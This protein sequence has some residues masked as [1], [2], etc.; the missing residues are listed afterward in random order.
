MQ[1][2]TVLILSRDPAFSR[3]ITAHWP[4]D[5]A[6]Q[7]DGPEFVV[8]DQAFRGGLESSHYDLAIVDAVLPVK[9]SRKKKDELVAKPAIDNASDAESLSR[10]VKHALVA[11]GKA[12]L[13]I[14]SEPGP[15]FCSV[16]GAVIAVRREAGTWPAMAGLLGSEILRRSQAECHARDAER[17]CHTA[18]AEATL[19][20]YMVEMRT[21]VNNALTTILGN[22]ELLAHEPG[23]PA[24]VQTQADALRNM[25][26]RLHEIFQRFSSIEKELSFAARESRP[27]ATGAAAGVR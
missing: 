10:D 5:P 20:R 25:A 2:S 16:D 22:A 14:H 17:I 15:D 12:A 23:L 6:G 27:E 21:N 7:G 8:L 24:K 18:L 4:R 26:L 3:E 13:V 11:A 19:G 9:R 1:R